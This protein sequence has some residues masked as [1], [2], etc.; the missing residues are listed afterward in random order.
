MRDEDAVKR[1]VKDRLSGKGPVVIDRW[2]EQPVY[3]EA[4]KK[5]SKGDKGVPTKDKLSHSS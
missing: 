5:S 3:A 4:T 1:D 2:H